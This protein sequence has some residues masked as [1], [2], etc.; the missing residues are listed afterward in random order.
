MLRTLCGRGRPRSQYQV[1][2][3]ILTGPV[4]VKFTSSKRVNV[5]LGARSPSFP[6]VSS[7][8]N[9]K[10]LFPPSQIYG[11]PNERKRPPG[12]ATVL[13]PKGEEDNTPLAHRDFG[14]GNL[15]LNSIFATQPT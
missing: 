9:S 6:A 2:R 11:V 1:A 10:W 4:P 15:V 14:Q 13:R 3:H 7:L 5:L 12:L 8:D